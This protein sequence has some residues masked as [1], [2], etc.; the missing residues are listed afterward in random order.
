MHLPLLLLSLSFFTSF[1]QAT[2]L[3][4][5]PMVGP[6]AMRSAT[7]WVQGDSPGGA[8]LSYWADAPA[9]SASTRQ[10][11]LSQRV[12]LEKD[13]DFAAHIPLNNLEPGGRY[14]YQVLV[15]GKAVS[16]VH[17][18]STQKLW[19]WRTSPPD[20]RV[21]LGSCTY[22]NEPA[23]DRPGTPYGG[24]TEIFAAMAAARPELTLWLGDNVYF[25][26]ADF[27]SPAGMAARYR[28]DRATPEL[29]TI[30]TTGSHAA[31][32]DDHDYG[33]NDA[34]STFIFKQQA[35]TLF[36]RY[37]ANP[38]YGMPDAAGAF[39]VVH[40]GDADFFL[41]DNRWYRDDDRLKSPHKAMF[42]DKQLHWLKNALLNSTSNF[43]FIVGGSQLLDT[44]SLYE[45]WR[46][47]ETERN[48]FLDWLGEQ[49][50]RGVIFLSGD[51]HH[52]ELLHWPR[53]GAY[54][55]YELTCSPLTSG[56]HDIAGEGKN[57]G[58][59]PG[60]L[61]GEKNFCSLDFSGDNANRQ[62]TMRV[63]DAKS[64][65]L[66]EK[67]ITKQELSYSAR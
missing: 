51:R 31:I 58:L 37:W 63:F 67:S 26:E 28:H 23:Y 54:P 42:G 29:Q 9:K 6:T 53:D 47:F 46:N 41:L 3:V 20:F 27:D 36:Q 14:A 59:V 44:Q 39:T 52:T 11:R 34:N 1:A 25:R 5:G 61:V 60:T 21:V 18:L 13:K 35:L 56:T 64:Q 57:P 50:M 4:A 45:G 66:W 32:W 17:Y 49:R 19:Q 7:V 55:L 48:A 40:Q 2:E 65:Q 12:K 22:I 8:E 38:S 24:G 43:K 33:P 15:N 10:K 30:L 16:P 62:V